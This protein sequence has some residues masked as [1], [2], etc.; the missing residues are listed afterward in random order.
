MC[1]SERDDRAIHRVAVHR[2]GAE[3]HSTVVVLAGATAKSLTTDGPENTSHD[4]HRRLV[5]RS[6]AGA[7]FSRGLGAG[8]IPAA[9]TATFVSG[10]DRHRPRATGSA[11]AHSRTLPREKAPGGDRR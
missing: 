2:S 6:E 4:A 7:G 11:A 10:T 3:T 9:Y 1:R 8:S 5:R